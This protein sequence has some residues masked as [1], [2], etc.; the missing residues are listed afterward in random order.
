MKFQKLNLLVVL[1]L[2]LGFSFMRCGDSVSQTV[3][4]TANTK[5]ETVKMEQ[6]KDLGMSEDSLKTKVQQKGMDALAAKK[7]ALQSEALQTLE[8]TTTALK[9][10]RKK[11]KKA[12]I[13]ALE[14]ATGKLEILLVQDPK[15]G[16]MP[17]DVDIQ[18]HDLVADLASIKS[19]K[20][21]A[22]KAIKDNYFQLAK[23]KLE[24]LASEI[25]IKT[26]ELPLK[27]YPSA[28]KVAAALVKDDKIDEA[29]LI[30]EEALNTIVLTEKRIPLP[31]IRAEVLISEA[32]SLDAKDEDKKKEVLQLLDNAEYQLILAEELGY[33]KRDQEYKE[34]NLAIK[35]IKKSVENDGDSQGIF[36][37]LKEKLAKFKK[38]I[39]A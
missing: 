21:A 2:I 13:E 25:R 30:L 32:T 20:K 6:P 12:A 31:I 19:I 22:Q 3:S 27:T 8:L 17:Y 29:K 16:L 37:N 36:K 4:E 38:R 34:L 23:T 9:A 10:L 26:Y 7:S 24:N 39:V 5:N 18:T 33:G 15:L 1:T 35:E 11:D 28:M 14:S